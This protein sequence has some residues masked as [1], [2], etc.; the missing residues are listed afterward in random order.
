MIDNLKK[1]I[2]EFKKTNTYQEF[3]ET[4]SNFKNIK[5]EISRKNININDI[6]LSI[7]NSTPKIKINYDLLNENFKKRLKNEKRNNL[8]MLFTTIISFIALIVAIISYF[9]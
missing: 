9:K 3:I 4:T 1:K 2:E 7:F 6:A 5:K 8:H